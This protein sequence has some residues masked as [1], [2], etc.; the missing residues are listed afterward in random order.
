MRPTPTR[1]RRAN[2]AGVTEFVTIGA[3]TS[4]LE[5]H[6]AKG[7]LEAEG[8]PAFLAHEN[9]VWAVWMYSQALGG[10]KL[11]VALDHAEEARKILQAHVAGEYETA[12]KTEFPDLE[13]NRCPRC[14][15]TSFRERPA[16]N[17]VLLALLTLGVF[18]LLFP[19][20][21][22]HCRCARCGVCWRR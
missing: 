8:I 4:P 15:S 14:G 21:K 19:L 22:E 20:T 16:W 12:L 11:Q 17:G 2:H 5:A 9:H 7:R 18:G 1:R 6:L 13:E 10:V 3:F